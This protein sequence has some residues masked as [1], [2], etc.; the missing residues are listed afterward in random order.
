MHS[1]LVYYLFY[2]RI[3]RKNEKRGTHHPRHPLGEFI[4]SCF[5]FFFLLF[6]AMPIFDCYQLLQARLSH[7]QCVVGVYHHFNAALRSALASS[8]FA[9]DQ[10]R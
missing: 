10:Q 1:K 6:F 2:D 5:F 7:G 9:A 8:A 3:V 4:F